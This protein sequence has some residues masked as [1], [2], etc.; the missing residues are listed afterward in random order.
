MTTEAGATQAK[1]APL[2]FRQNTGGFADVSSNASIWLQ[3]YLWSFQTT[4]R[5][6]NI[7][8]LKAQ[9]LTWYSKYKTQQ[10]H[11]SFWV[12]AFRVKDC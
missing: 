4:L 9:T 12:P 8:S 3:L 10:T 2:V 5:L 7:N 6:Q 1:Q 11:V